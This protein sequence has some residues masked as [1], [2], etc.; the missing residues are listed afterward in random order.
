MVHIA[1]IWL[2]FCRKN[3]SKEDFDFS[4]KLI[5]GF[6]EYQMQITSGDIQIHDKLVNILVLT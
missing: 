1:V 3:M 2:L 6:H 4:A 5:K